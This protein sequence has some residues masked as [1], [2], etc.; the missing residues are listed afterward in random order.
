MATLLPLLLVAAA[1][2]DLR[3][4]TLALVLLI[5]LT[6]AASILA[7][8]LPTLPR[9][10]A[11]TGVPVLVVVLGIGALLVRYARPGDDARMQGV[12]IAVALLT[13]GFV[14]A[15]SRRSGLPPT[16]MADLADVRLA[17]VDD[18]QPVCKDGYLLVPIE[19]VAPAGRRLDLLAPSLTITTVTGARV[20]TRQPEWGQV[21]GTWGALLP[22]RES[23]ASWRVVGSAAAPR[24]TTIA[25]PLSAD[26]RTTVCGRI[27]RV[28]LAIDV[29]VAEARRLVEVPVRAG[30]RATAPGGRATIRRVAGTTESL[31]LVVQVDRMSREHDVD[32]PLDGATYALI[33]PSTGDAYPSGDLT[34]MP[35]A[36]GFAVLDVPGFV[37][38]STGELLIDFPLARSGSVRAPVASPSRLM[39]LVATPRDR[40]PLRV[41]REAVFHSTTPR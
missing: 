35:G 18:A 17:V 21:M 15:A 32:P 10:W 23:G 22:L 36:N 40:L 26:E 9:P 16:T 34:T 4:F 28:T 2:R 37:H 5:G 12:I 1:S 14:V 19:A 39:L 33:D 11:D 20:V 3:G 41:Q 38:A 30:A 6:I 25:F 13:S 31:Q 8:T 27:A 29:R 24:R 7:P